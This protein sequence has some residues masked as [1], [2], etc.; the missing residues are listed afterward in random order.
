VILLN[1]ENRW[2]K[3]GASLVLQNNVVQVN[4]FNKRI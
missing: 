2:L 3:A 1:T 4:N